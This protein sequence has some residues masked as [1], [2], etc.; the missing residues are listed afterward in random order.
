MKALHWMDRYRKEVLQL[1][2]RKHGINVQYLYD[3]NK[4]LASASHTLFY[5][6]RWRVVYFD[7]LSGARTLCISTSYRVR[8]IPKFQSKYISPNHFM[9]LVKAVLK[10]WRRSRSNCW[11]NIVWRGFDLPSSKI[12]FFCNVCCQA[13]S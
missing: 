11:S 9:K 1:S 13:A 10:F 3:N 6:I 2:T 12:N 5:L 4:Y 7:Q 8:A